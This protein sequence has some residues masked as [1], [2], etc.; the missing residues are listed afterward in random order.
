[1]INVGKDTQIRKM[2]YN[3]K[4]HTFDIEFVCLSIS[5]LPLIKRLNKSNFP[6]HAKVT[7]LNKQFFINEEVKVWFKDEAELKGEG[8]KFLT[9]KNKTLKSTKSPFQLGKKKRELLGHK[10]LVGFI[11]V[12]E[13]MK[14][15]VVIRSGDK[16]W[17]FSESE[18]RFIVSNEIYTATGKTV[19]MKATDGKSPWTYDAKSGTIRKEDLI[20]DHRI[21][22]DIIDVLRKAEVI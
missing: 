9:E 22:K 5:S 12:S 19:T 2:T 1:M 6:D 7:F 8:W 3:E 13:E 18:I 4:A 17:R 21:V 20:L 16:T 10:G 14:P 15:Y 11:G